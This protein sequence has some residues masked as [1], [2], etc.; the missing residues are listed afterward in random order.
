V[1]TFYQRE[2]FQNLLRN[3]ISFFE[4]K[5][6]ASGA[7]MSRLS[8]D[9]KLLAELIGF[10]GIFPLVGVFNIVGCII[11]GFVFGWKLTLV[12]FCSAMPVILVSSYFRIDYEIKFDAL[13]QKVFANS[14]QFATEAVGAFRTV[15]SLTMEDS[16]ISKYS[17]LLQEQIRAAT[18]RATH[19]CLVFALCD[20]LDFLAMALTFWY[21]AVMKPLLIDSC[22]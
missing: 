16:I 19:A 22:I 5:E 9:F 12:V 8:T 6:N 7:L 18:R 15:T 20:S 13:N 2:H 14:S 1:S 21:V 4:A 11:I 3:P 10:N 17:S